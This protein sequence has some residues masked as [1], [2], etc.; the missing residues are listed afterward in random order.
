MKTPE[1]S[2]WTLCASKSKS[3]RAVESGEK[4]RVHNGDPA[5]LKD[6]P[7]VVQKSRRH[8][9]LRRAQAVR[10]VSFL[11]RENRFGSADAQGTEAHMRKE[12]RCVRQDRPLSSRKAKDAIAVALTDC[13]VNKTSLFLPRL[14]LTLLFVLQRSSLAWF[15]QCSHITHC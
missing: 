12:E 13:H 8:G 6:R 2:P 4:G 14:P 5:R 9:R 15:G 3:L 11:T 10:A 1:R 7:S